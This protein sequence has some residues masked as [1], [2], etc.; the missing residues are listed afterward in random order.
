M[1]GAFLL[2]F[3]AAVTFPIFFLRKIANFPLVAAI[4]AP[5]ASMLVFYNLSIIL[6][7][8]VY[9]TSQ[10]PGVPL[11]YGL[12]A[13]FVVFWLHTL[14]FLF[15]SRW[16]KTSIVLGAALL[17]IYILVVAWMGIHQSD[18]QQAAQDRQNLQDA[19]SMSFALYAPSPA[20][21]SLKPLNMTAYSSPGGPRSFSITYTTGWYNSGRSIYID[22]REFSEYDP[23]KKCDYLGQINGYSFDYFRAH[24]NNP[25]ECVLIGKTNNCDV[26]VQDPPANADEQRYFCMIEKTLVTVTTGKDNFTK[27]EVIGVLNAMK[28]ANIDTLNND[29]RKLSES[30]KD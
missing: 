17:A 23:P 28:T 16:K 30:H 19:K 8:I 6:S 2:F 11:S 24:A 5:A 13:Y 20:P 7:G 18:L 22:E 4:F 3:S 21:E 10:N 14:L 26:Y 9:S 27:D 25:N 12:I 29:I 1:F 15:I